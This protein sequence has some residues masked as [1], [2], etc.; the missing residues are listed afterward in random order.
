MWAGGRWVDRFHPPLILAEVLAK[1][2]PL[3]VLLLLLPPSDF[4][5]FLRPCLLPLARLK[6][7]LDHICILFRRRDH[8]LFGV[9]FVTLNHYKISVLVSFLFLMLILLKKCIQF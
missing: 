9:I 7:L 1:A 3:N 6:E 4:Q 5:T 8:T 2:V